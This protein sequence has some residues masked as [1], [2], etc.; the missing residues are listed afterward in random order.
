[1][2]LNLARRMVLALALVAGGV[3]ASFMVG[4]REGSAL[5]LR[6][7]WTLTG[8]QDNV[9]L[10]PGAQLPPPGQS[11]FEIISF[12][13]AGP[14]GALASYV[15]GGPDL[16]AASGGPQPAFVTC[17]AG[18]GSATGT[19]VLD[20]TNAFPY[21]GCVYFPTVKNTGQRPLQ[22][23]LGSLSDPANVFCGAPTCKVDIVAGGTTPQ[24]ARQHC[25]AEGVVLRLAPTSRYFL[26]P[27]ASLTCALFVVLL[28]PAA[29]GTTYT[30]VIKAPFPEDPPPPGGGSDP[31][32][33][34][35]GIPGLPAPPIPEP[36]G[37]ASPD[38][39][40]APSPTA[41]TDP[42]ATGP[43]GTGATPTPAAPVVGAIAPLPPDSGSGLVLGAG[44]V[45]GPSVLL[46]VAAFAC[47]L[48]AVLVLFVPGRLR[49]RAD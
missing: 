14:T 48:S 39:G 38:P 40:V 13:A 15:Y 46:G 11:G 25:V 47:F 19:I 41:P 4:E 5:G 18:T 22:I 2:S 37:T 42:G 43:S 20:I 23:E 34:D 36:S 27:G 7:T 29:E 45:G 10:R 49:R 32:P 8:R 24:S 16:A 12:A 28:Q 9:T 33:R 6:A 26:A 35:P 21:A 44:R 3:L 30:I 1:M 31:T 17:T